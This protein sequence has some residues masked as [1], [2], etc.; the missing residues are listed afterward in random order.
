LSA[1]LPITIGLA[2]G[3]KPREADTVETAR[4]EAPPAILLPH[5]TFT[6][7]AKALEAVIEETDPRVVGFGEF[8]QQTGT[9]DTL[10]TIERFADQL[11]PVMAQRTSDLVVETWVSEG[12]CGA[13]EK[14]VVSD[15]NKV[16]KR[17]DETEDENLR[18]LK[19]AKTLGV[20]PHI[21]KMVCADYDRVHRADGGVDYL[22]MLE[23]VA[24]RLVET[25]RNILEKRPSGNHRMIAVFSGAIHNDLYPTK[26]WETFSYGP[27]MQKAARG[28]YVEIDIYVPE[29][30]QAAS[31]SREEI[32]YGTVTNLA[33]RETAALIELG[34]NSYI[35]V[36]PKGIK[37]PRT[38]PD[39]LT[40]GKKDK[41]VTR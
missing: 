40:E 32:W 29:F 24:R 10:S 12:R 23:L 7:A 1:L 41:K 6:C 8:H 31:S 38:S 37:A 33:S 9:T 35:I 34:K 2:C 39:H 15:V 27:A 26:D 11:L 3:E 16:S 36:F 25:T 28:R 19:A 14:Q 13:V 18:M 4:E 5:R 17:P 21:L 30:V 20:Q 22:E